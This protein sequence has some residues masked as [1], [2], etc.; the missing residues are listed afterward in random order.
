MVYSYLVVEDK[1]ILTIE[2]ESSQD[3]SIYM[4]YKKANWFPA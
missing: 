2:T 4:D 1:S 3:D